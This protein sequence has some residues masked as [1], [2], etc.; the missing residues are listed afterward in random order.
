MLRRI[1]IFQLYH[2]G[3]IPELPDRILRNLHTDAVLDIQR[4]F[5]HF[6]RGFCCGLHYAHFYNADDFPDIACPNFL[7]NTLG[8]KK[9][10]RLSIYFAPEIK[11]IPF[12]IGIL[13]K[14]SPRF[15]FSTICFL[16]NRLVI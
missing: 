14:S 7:Y 11:T 1:Q 16:S 12:D 3:Q 15:Y 13:C 9:R 5:A 10:A 4:L 8:T 6:V 2:D